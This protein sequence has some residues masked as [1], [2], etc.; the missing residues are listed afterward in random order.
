MPSDDEQA[1]RTLVA[2]S[3]RFLDEGRFADYLDLYAEDGSYQLEAHAAEIGRDMVWL[4]LN[5]AELAELFREWP[6]HVRDEAVRTH[7]ATLEEITLGRGDA[8]ATAL[9]TF[10]VFRTDEKGRS[11]L[12]CVGHYEDEFEA[13][14]G[15]WKL[16]HRRVRLITRLLVTPTPLPL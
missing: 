12:Y 10:A 15:V 9:S 6:L 13:I 4:S 3:G 16:R 1:I 5:R 14:A 11:E 7:L 8:L 2:R